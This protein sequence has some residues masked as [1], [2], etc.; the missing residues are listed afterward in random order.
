MAISRIAWATQWPRFNIKLDLLCVWH[1]QADMAVQPFKLQWKLHQ[2]TFRAA[3]FKISSVMHGVSSS[4]LKEG[5]ISLGARP[6][7]FQ[8]DLNA[9]RPWDA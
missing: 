7:R 4:I 5:A 3:L 1:R 8:T 6:Y 9:M 2:H